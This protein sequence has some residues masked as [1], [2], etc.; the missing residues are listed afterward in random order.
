[1]IG[2]ILINTTSLQ[3]LRDRSV[4][5]CICRKPYDNRAMIACDQCD[6]WYHFDCINL[7]SPPPETFFCP[8]CRP[9]NG[10]ESISLPRSDHD[11]DRYGHYL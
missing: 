1:L 9:N 11:E 5:Y 2:H 8:A 4:L 3:L 10:E 6:E 7:I